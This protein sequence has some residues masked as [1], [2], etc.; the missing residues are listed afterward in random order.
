MM[1]IEI[2]NHNNTDTIVTCYF[3]IL[4]SLSKTTYYLNSGIMNI[5]ITRSW[6]IMFERSAIEKFWDIFRTI[7]I[8]N[9]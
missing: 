3:V 4:N 6:T 9:N 8:F 7:V 5:M 1:I 2:D